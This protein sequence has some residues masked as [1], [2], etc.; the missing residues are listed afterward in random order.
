[1]LKINLRMLVER[2]SVRNVPTIAAT[3]SSPKDPIASHRLMRQNNFCPIESVG[4][5]LDTACVPFSYIAQEENLT[6]C[7]EQAKL[8]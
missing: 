7:G 1:M 6:V 5:Y 4:F 2:S 8:N 3:L